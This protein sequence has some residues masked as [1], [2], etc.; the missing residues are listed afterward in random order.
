MNDAYGEAFAA[1]KVAGMDRAREVLEQVTERMKET[2]TYPD[3]ITYPLSKPVGKDGE[4]TSL[5]IQDPDGSVMKGLGEKGG[6]DELMTLIGR[7]SGLPP[8]TIRQ[9]KMRDLGEIG[10]IMA[11]FTGS[12]PQTGSE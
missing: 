4:I 9:I 2:K 11:F 3:S 12:G 10:E 8:S 1:L 7:T 5:E 6:L